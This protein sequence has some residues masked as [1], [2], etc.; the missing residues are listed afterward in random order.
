MA[1][2]REKLTAKEQRAQN[3][4]LAS[5]KIAKRRTKKPIIVAMVGLVGSGKSSV[6]KE[7]AGLIGANII[8]GDKIRVLLRKE[9][10]KYEGTR[11]IAENAAWEII[12]QGG[13]VI[14]DF[15]HIDPKKR[16]SLRTKA[17]GVKASIF[18]ICTYADIDVIVGRILTAAY[19]NRVDDFFGG[20]SSKWK[21]TEQSKGAVVKLREMLRR[22]PLHYNWKNKGG[23]QWVIKNPPCAVL[24]DI[25]T[26][27]SDW[28]QEVQKIAKKLL[29]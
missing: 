19:R 8:E 9:G 27:D 7:L 4:F 1:H 2:K 21:G 11:K 13:N 3:A 17:R 28:K 24:A 10:E 5:L 25:D 6:A 20:A 15:D 22:L 26:T 18:F 23:G 29:K 16:A 12:K 14:M